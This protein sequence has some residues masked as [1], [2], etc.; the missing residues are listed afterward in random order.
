MRLSSFG[1]Y[2]ARYFLVLPPKIR[3]VMT[4]QP[5]HTSSEYDLLLEQARALVLEIGVRAERQVVDAVEALGSGSEQLMDEI[6]QS[7]KDINALELQIDELCAQIIAKRQPAATD[8]RMVIMLTKSTTDLERI[9]DEGKKIAL[10]A[11]KLYQEGRPTLPRYVEVRRMTKL[12]VDM[13]RDVL[14]GIDAM[15]PQRMSEII[16]RD[17]EVDLLLEGVIR[18]LMTLM[19][20]DPRTISAAL[21]LMFIAK[22][23]ERV[24]DHVKNIAEHLIYAVLGADVRHQLLGAFTS[25]GPHAE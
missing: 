25:D 9:G 4:P 12:V 10:F 16:A 13:L 15:D 24:G 19:M 7:E 23:L 22:A 18:Q 1:S 3:S 21:D 14:S 17:A 11:R 6:L 8:L 5:P 20:E 2:D